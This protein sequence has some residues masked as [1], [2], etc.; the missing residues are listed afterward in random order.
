MC[1]AIALHSDWLHLKDRVPQDSILGP[2][3]FLLFINGITRVYSGTNLNFIIYVDTT[4]FFSRNNAGTAATETNE[5]LADIQSW[6]VSNR[7]RVT[8]K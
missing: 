4:I 6:T 3:R 5:I 7:L 1:I 8:C 2:L